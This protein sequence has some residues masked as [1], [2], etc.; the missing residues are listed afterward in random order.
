M[1]VGA[2]PK[3]PVDENPLGVVV[4]RRNRRKKGDAPQR[5][6][7]RV[8]G[9][10]PSILDG[11]PV[12]AAVK[13]LS[14]GGQ[15]GKMI[16]DTTEW[17]LDG[18]RKAEESYKNNNSQGERLGTNR[19]V[20]LQL[21]EDCVNK[22]AVCK[23]KIETE[24]DDFVQFCIENG[25]GKETILSLKSDW[26]RKKEQKQLLEN[27]RSKRNR[28]EIKEERIGICCK[29][30][31]ECKD[32]KRLEKVEMKYSRKFQGKG[33]NGEATNRENCSW[34]EINI[35]V[36]LGTIAAG[37][38]PSDMQTLLTFL[39]I[40]VPK[41]FPYVTFSKLENL[42]G[43]TF[44]QIRDESMEEGLK[45][46]VEKETGMKYEEWLV[47]DEQIGVYGSYDMG[48]NK[49]SSGN[50][51]D[52]L[53]GH[54]FLIGCLCK[55][56][57]AARIASKKCSTCAIK[58]EE[59]E[60]APPHLCPLNHEGSSKSMEADSA[61]IVVKEIFR[62]NN[63]KIFIKGIVGDDDSS[64]KAIL[65][66][67]TNHPKGKL[68][69]DIPEPI[70]LADPGHRIKT[71]ARKIYALVPLPKSQSTCVNGDAVRFKMNFGYFLKRH[72]NGTLEEMRI[73]KNAVIDH[74]FDFHEY[75]S[76]QWCLPKKEQ[77]ERKNLPDVESEGHL[78]LCHP[79]P[80]HHK[81]KRPSYYRCMIADAPLRK[82]MWSIFGPCVTDPKLE[83]SLHNFET[84][85]NEMMNQVI[86]K[87][88]PK[89][90]FLGSTMA[91]THRIAVAVSIHNYGHSRFWNEA[92]TDLEMD[93]PC[94]LTMHLQA[95][96]R[97]KEWKRNYQSKKEVKRKRNRDTFEKIQEGMK[98]LRADKKRG[99]TYDSG[100]NMNNEIPPEVEAMDRKR[101]E[102]RNVQC[103][104]K[105]CYQACHSRRSSKACTY[106][107]CP[108][109]ELESKIYEK[110]RE[111]YPS[112]FSK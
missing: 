81:P 88:C 44:K 74:S 102:E 13:K 66:H 48:W 70:W 60:E 49:R 92:F 52:S 31:L 16:K 104:L 56:I 63:K 25:I 109:N 23:C 3:T 72:R 57:I 19:I 38:G 108:K 34:H 95:K 33:Y 98:K 89:H 96:D 10:E 77:E 68:P 84:Q 80:P 36:V 24:I 103:N 41:S 39:D 83:E 50:R 91:L 55:K 97:R 46:E 86:A 17:N 73:A 59:G 9:E 65:K 61:L 18:V 40:P 107:K 1:M 106:Y 64:T 71:V 2:A 79:C 76:T 94:L 53:T 32:C 29:P 87:Y 78:G 54:A 26:R 42:I 43:K 4:K 35:K 90:K 7:R 85:T 6:S 37:I 27:D 111:C 8:K 22:M 51:Y 99:S 15:G 11:S 28:I 45:E 105:G 82:Q 100:M 30:Y 112:Y 58:R 21:I 14:L 110:L 62:K 12:N 69:P 67:K 75:C 101:K 93:L 20:D 47:K 5:S